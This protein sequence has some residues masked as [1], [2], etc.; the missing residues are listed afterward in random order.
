[1]CAGA[2][3]FTPVLNTVCDRPIGSRLLASVG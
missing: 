1:M 3:V 2:T